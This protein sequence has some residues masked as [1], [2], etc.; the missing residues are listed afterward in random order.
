[1]SKM[2]TFKHLK[3]W[4]LAKIFPTNFH[5]I[6]SKII[7]FIMK[8][9]FFSD[10]YQPITKQKNLNLIKF[11]NFHLNENRNIFCSTSIICPSMTHVEHMNRVELPFST[12]ISFIIKTCN[13]I[14]HFVLSLI[15]I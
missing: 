13:T 7:N 8:I 4:R 6:L 3:F 11:E 15:H 10:I 14:S 9:N 1:M 12:I 5:V 2:E